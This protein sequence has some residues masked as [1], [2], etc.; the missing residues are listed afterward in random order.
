MK[1]VQLMINWFTL[2]VD[3]LWQGELNLAQDKKK[4]ISNVHI[5]IIIFLLLSS[6]F[7]LTLHTI[8]CKAIA[9]RVRPSSQ[10]N[11]FSQPPHP[12]TEVLIPSSI[13][14]FKA[15]YHLAP[16]VPYYYNMLSIHSYSEVKKL[17]LCDCDT[18][19]DTIL[20]VSTLACSN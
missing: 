11:L 17:Q 12:W 8:K 20:I 7:L 1:A 18:V 3:L 6:I 5:Y 13:A 4:N 9:R 10:A 14:T 16:I 2:I 19:Q 15:E